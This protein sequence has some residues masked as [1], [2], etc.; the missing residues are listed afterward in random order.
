MIQKSSHE[1]LSNLPASDNFTMTIAKLL[2]VTLILVDIQQA[3]SGDINIKFN[4]AK[5]TEFKDVIY[6]FK[7]KCPDDNLS[8][9]ECTGLLQKAIKTIVEKALLKRPN[10]KIP[11]DKLSSEGLANAAK[12]YIQST[13]PAELQQASAD[14]IYK[15][16]AKDV[17]AKWSNIHQYSNNEKNYPIPHRF[18]LNVFGMF[19]THQCTLKV[20]PKQK[21]GPSKK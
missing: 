12:A 18:F 6:E 21:P 20:D 19:V 2:A 7:N 14:A 11:L 10:E 5:C 1:T 4:E 16:M 3:M 13:P 8:N 9:K 17:P 15:S